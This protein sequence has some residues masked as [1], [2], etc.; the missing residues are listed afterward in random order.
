M[1][2]ANPTNKVKELLGEHV[3]FVKIC[4]I[5]DVETAIATAEAGADF[6]GLVFANSR[7]Q[8][9][10]EKAQEIVAALRKWRKKEDVDL[11]IENIPKTEDAIS[12]FNNAA[13]KV[14]ETVNSARPLI[15]G[16]FAN[17]DIE[18]MNKIARE[19]PLDIV[20]LSGKEGW[21]IGDEISKPS[22]RC[23]HVGK[24]DAT[25]IIS[26]F[27]PGRFVNIL[28]DTSDPTAMGGTGVTFD[29][30]IAKEIQKSVQVILAGGLD[31]E[32]VRHAVEEVRPF[33]VDVSSGVETNGT[34]DIDKI[35]R[36]IVNAKY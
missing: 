31:P 24:E 14:T 7:R 13:E 8:V 26:G 30:G 22:W 16:V 23:V 12:W 2:A 3:S 29:W 21:T 25:H 32:N 17:N 34:K 11:R 19:V 9:S 33:M 10:I 20:Q 4:G 36:F 27:V 5:K 28:L 15:V 6:I 18:M 1:V 35:Q